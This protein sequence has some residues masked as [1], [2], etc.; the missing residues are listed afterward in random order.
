MIDEIHKPYIF[1]LNESI[2]LINQIKLRVER[3]EEKREEKKKE[4]RDNI[5]FIMKNLEIKIPILENRFN[6]LLNILQFAEVN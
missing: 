3:D 1:Q 6:E 4:V 5:S 2:K